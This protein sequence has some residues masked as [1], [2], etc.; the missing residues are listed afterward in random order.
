MEEEY[1]GCLVQQK[2]AKAI[3]DLLEF[4]EVM[5]S[6]D[7]QEIMEN[8]YGLLILNLVKNVLHQVDEEDRALKVCTNSN[9]FTW[10]NLCLIRFIL[11]TDP[12]KTD[13]SKNLEENFDE[14]KKITV[15]LANIDE[16]IS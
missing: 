5:K 14:F 4:P 7:E 6:S 11:K 10:V 1:E 3:R 9:P 16:K 13:P 15:S 12:S 8:P 2:C